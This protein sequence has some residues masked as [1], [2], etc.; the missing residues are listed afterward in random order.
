MTYTLHAAPAAPS[1]DPDW[2]SPIWA[3]ANTAEICHFRPESSPHRPRSR[4]RLCYHER[5]LEGIFQVQDQFVRCVRTRYF[6]DVWK[7]SCVEFFAQPRPDRGYFNFEFNCGGAFLC[8][9]ITNPERTASGFKEFV[10]L[11][12][13]LGASIQ[14]RS[15]LPQRVEPELSEP[16]TWTLRFSIPFALFAPYLGPLDA[17][18]GQLWRGNFFKC[19]EENSHPHW[20]AWA[21]VDAFNFHR[22]GCFGTLRFD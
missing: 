4:V 3:G 16:V 6:D 10:R 7:D 1:M 20:A 12:P 13:Q 19:A 15:S 9:Y 11:P 18:P 21:P 17:K 2:S 22:P 8:S 5:G 14:T